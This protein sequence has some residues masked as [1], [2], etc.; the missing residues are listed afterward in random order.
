MIGYALASLP[1]PRFVRHSPQR[2]S[3]PAGMPTARVVG[4][5]TSSATS[6]THPY[7]RAGRCHKHGRGIPST[8]SSVSYPTGVI[9]RCN[10]PL[11]KYK[12]GLSPIYRVLKN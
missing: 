3:G 9:R 1:G 6:V 10:F 4:A 12:Q 8:F 11:Q 7:V 5:T 2:C